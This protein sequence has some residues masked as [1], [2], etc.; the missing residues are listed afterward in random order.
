MNEKNFYDFLSFPHNPEELFTLLYIIEK[1]ENYEIYKAIYIETRE[2]YA[3][4]II[5]LDNKIQYHKLKQ[6][7]LILKSL[8]KNENIIHYYGSFFSFK[9][10]NI[11]LVFEY[12][13]PGSLYDFLIAIERPLIEQEIAIIINDILCGLVL[14]HQLNIVH[15]NIKLTNILLSENG[16]SKL[17]NFS[18][19]NQKLDNFTNS[20]EKSVNELNNPKYDIFLLGIVCLELFKSQKDFDRNKFISLVKNNNN[21]I[22]SVQNIVEKNFFAGKEQLCSRDFIDFVQKCL[23]SNPYKRPTAFELKNHP[24]IKRNLNE[25]NS[26]RTYFFN[27]IKYSI[28]KIEYSKKAKNYN[29]EEKSIENEKN[30]SQKNTKNIKKNENE[31][32]KNNEIEKTIEREDG[33][34]FSHIYSS[35]QNSITKRDND[36]SSYID[37]KGNSSI[38]I[39]NNVTSK[40][41]NNFADKLAEFRMEQMRKNEEVEFDKYT[42]KDILV[43]NSNL[44]NTGFHYG[45]D[46]SFEKSPKESAV[47]GKTKSKKMIRNKTAVSNK[48]TFNYT[49][50]L[51]G[52]QNKDNNDNKIEENKETK[53]ISDNLQHIIDLTEKEKFTR[54]DSNDVDY[55]KANWEHLNKYKHIIDNNNKVSETNFNYDDNSHFLRLNSDDDSFDINNININLNDN[56]KNNDL[57]NNNNDLNNNNN[58]LNNN[59]NDLNK[60]DFNDN[61]FNDN[62]LN[63][64]DFND[65]DFNDNDLND[66]NNTNNDYNISINIDDNIDEN[67]N[68]NYNENNNKVFTKYIPFSDMKCNIIQLGTT[69]KKYIT[70]QK[71]KI[72]SDSEYSLKNSIFK[73]N[74]VNNILD[75]KYNN[76]KKLLLS[77]G[78]NHGF[79]MEVNLKKSYTKEKIFKND[80]STCFTSFNTPISKIKGYTENFSTN[81]LY[82]SC[83]PFFTV[84][85]KKIPKLKKKIKN[86]PKS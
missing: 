40:K 15:S 81:Q 67:E 24:F 35:D 30:I 68:T 63:N 74:E 6:E 9:S 76:H 29:S 80:I 77:F 38:N 3:I 22:N 2:I 82:S 47:F 12:C 86:N 62:D 42:N 50:I 44:D 48:K 73:A 52:E 84:Q 4:K 43:D 71:P 85:Q 25:T 39:N 60:N 8:V 10:K 7:S 37:S 5:P 59:N 78:N 33:M 32:E 75:N 20:M 53:A 19:A 69:V 54:K 17:S 11:W 41:T 49:K 61:D 56:T 1:N 55:L 36:K 65:N 26:E 72:N 18:Y 83:K 16:V 34:K 58:D 23:T 70:P 21:N 79:D 27:L 57:N 31:N 66:N 51:N 14:M 46:D 13:P 45:T 64:K 28:E